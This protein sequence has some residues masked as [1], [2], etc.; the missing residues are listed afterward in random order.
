MRGSKSRPG[1]IRLSALLSAAAC[2]ASGT[3]LATC[4][5][6]LSGISPGNGAVPCYIKVQPI[7]V[8]K[9]TS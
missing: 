6:S 7:D 8:C 5:P 4:T 1:R 9:S 2:L 3:A